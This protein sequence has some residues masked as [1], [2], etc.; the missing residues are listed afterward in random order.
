MSTKTKIAILIIFVIP[1]DL[2]RAFVFQRLWN[3][4]VIPYG[5]MEFSVLSIAGLL[6]ILD[7]VKISCFSGMRQEEEDD[8]KNLNR[9]INNHILAPLLILIAGMIY[10]QLL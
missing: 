3:W 7:M 6:L 9:L 10:K 5:V 4:F 2:W 8:I 1:V